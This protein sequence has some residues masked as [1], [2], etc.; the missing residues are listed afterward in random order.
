MQAI[1]QSFLQEMRKQ[2]EVEGWMTICEIADQEK[3]PH[4]ISN[5][6]KVME[7]FTKD[8]ESRDHEVEGVELQQYYYKKKGHAAKDMLGWGVVVVLALLVQTTCAGVYAGWWLG[9]MVAQGWVCEGSGEHVVSSAGGLKGL[10]CMVLH[11]WVIEGSGLH[12]VAGL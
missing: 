9:C 10:R 11:V 6:D 12:C 8:L 1:E 4:G 5:F 2:Q 3:T 7:Q